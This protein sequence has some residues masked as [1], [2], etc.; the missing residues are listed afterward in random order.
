MIWNLDF[1]THF[2]LMWPLLQLKFFSQC[3]TIFI[4]ATFSQSPFIVKIGSAMYIWH[5]CLCNKRKLHLCLYWYIQYLYP[6]FFYVWICVIYPSMIDKLFWNLIRKTN[7][8]YVAFSRRIVTRGVV[9]RIL[10]FE[11][12]FSSMW[13]RWNDVFLCM[14]L[15]HGWYIFL[16]TEFAKFSGVWIYLC[17]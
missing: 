16:V 13:L 1:I 11:V 7:V 17:V 2:I 6:K 12:K 5:S 14:C 15:N 8:S 3:F 9:K 4:A 10:Q